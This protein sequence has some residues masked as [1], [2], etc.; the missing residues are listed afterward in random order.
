L[1]RLYDDGVSSLHGLILQQLNQFRYAHS[2]LVQDPLESLRCEDLAR[3]DRD[4][5]LSLPARVAERP[6]GRPL[7]QFDTSR[8]ARA[9]GA[10][11]LR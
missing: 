3:V 1:V 11:V 5:N 4:N 9:P 2:C 7:G 6:N 10:A 8:R